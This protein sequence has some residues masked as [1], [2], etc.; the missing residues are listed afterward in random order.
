MLS[1]DQEEAFQT[2]VSEDGPFFLT[3]EAGSGKSYLIEHMRE[4]IPGCRVTA[5]TGSAAQLIGGT[6]LH[7]FAGIHPRYGL[8]TSNAVDR[9]IHGCSVLIIDEISMASE[10]LMDKLYSRL[11]SSITPTK[12]VVVGDLMQLHPVEGTPIF[13]SKDWERYKILKLTSQHRQKDQDFLRILNKVRIGNLDEEVMEFVRSRTVD[14]LPDTCTHLMSKRY[15]VENRN[16]QVLG[17]LPGPATSFEMIVKENVRYDS[18]GRRKKAPKLDPQKVRMPQTL[19]IKPGARIVMLNNTKRWFNGSTGYVSSIGRNGIT[20]DL[21]SGSTEHV[22]THMMEV[23][24][25]DGNVTHYV[26]QYPMMLA[27]AFTIHKS[28]GMSLDRVGINLDDHFA[29]GQTY[30]ALS[31]CRTPDGLFL[32]GAMD[33]VLTDPDALACYEG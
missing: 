4:N 1:R 21:D 32:S 33:G 15:S 30:V 17:R 8:I 3:G 18:R 19:R 9:R 22:E 16:N 20:V 13:K 26:T 12:L 10:D 11:R 7:S 14:V 28:Q 31:R 25:G 24:D 6:T 29:Y 5:M 27:W 2:I 23:V